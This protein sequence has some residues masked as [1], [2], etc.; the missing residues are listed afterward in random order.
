ML[1]VDVTLK[2]FARLPD[3]IGVLNSIYRK[4]VDE[5]YDVLND[6][7]FHDKDLGLMRGYSGIKLFQNTYDHVFKK[8][9]ET[10]TSSLHIINELNDHLLRTHNHYSFSNG[11]PGIMWYLAYLCNKSFINIENKH[12]FSEIESYID[13][14]V[15]TDSTTKNYD[16]FTGLIGQILFYEEAKIFKNKIELQRLIIKNLY[17]QLIQI[18]ENEL[19]WSF[20]SYSFTN[21]MLADKDEINFGLSHGLPSLVSC[22][23][24]FDKM[25]DELL[26]KLV[27]GSINYILSYQSNDEIANIGISCFPSHVKLH[28]SFSDVNYNSRLAWCYG[29]LGIACMLWNAGIRFDSKYWKEKSIEVIL[30]SSTRRKLLENSV[31]DATLCHGSAGIAHIFNRF[32]LRTKHEKIKQAA[33]YWADVTIEMAKYDD[34]LAGYRT[35]IS[36]DNTAAN[37]RLENEFGFLEGISGTGLALLGFIDHKTMDWDKCLLIS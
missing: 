36:I 33:F 7:A 30:K 13:K 35:P 32:Y 23:L 22:L 12:F 26:F 8:K 24:K 21:N 9:S 31:I 37:M 16:L 5:I 34:G 27:S 28:D 1:A 25:H 4:K 14:N 20:S 10:N 6:H 17:D 3:F 2:D 29:D 15:V 11:I 19:T 18:N